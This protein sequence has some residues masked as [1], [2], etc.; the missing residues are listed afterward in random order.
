VSNKL[1][2]HNDLHFDYF[3]V[4]CIKKQIERLFL[5]NRIVIEC[6]FWKAPV[7]LS[8]A[9]AFVIFAVSTTFIDIHLRNE[10]SSYC[11]FYMDFCLLLDRSEP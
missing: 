1:K 6:I 5:R 11:N 8:Y 9:D 3:L 4:Y 10:R 7:S 2:F